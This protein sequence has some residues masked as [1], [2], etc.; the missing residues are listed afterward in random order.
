MQQIEKFERILNPIAHRLR[1]E[2]KSQI[3]LWRESRT[4]GKSWGIEKF[5]GVCNG[6]I[7]NKEIE[8]WLD[9]QGLGKELREAQK[10]VREHKERKAANG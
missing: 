10:Q 5:K 9:A 7:R 6:W 4:K 1:Q 8:E 3:G 2:N